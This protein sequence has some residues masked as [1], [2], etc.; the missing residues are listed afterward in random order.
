MSECRIKG[1]RYLQTTCVTCGR[2]VI[3]KTLPPGAHWIFMKDLEPTEE[4]VII[5][6]SDCTDEQI[7]I[8]IPESRMVI[9]KRTDLSFDDIEYW[10]EIPKEPK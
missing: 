4:G 8:V 3:T 1:C 2:L 5:F 6:K 10:M 9:L 7:G